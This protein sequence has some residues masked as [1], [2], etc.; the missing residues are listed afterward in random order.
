MAHVG[1]SHA[2]A[3]LDLPFHHIIHTL[4]HMQSLSSAI[5][6]LSLS[7]SL[8][9][10]SAIL[11]HDSI[12]VHVKS[13]A[14]SGLQR[15]FGRK[16][17]FRSPSPDRCSH[18]SGL[19]LNQVLQLTLGFLSCS[20]NRRTIKVEIKQLIWSPTF[21]GGFSTWK[22]SLPFTT[23]SKLCI[24]CSPFLSYFM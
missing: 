8:S 13:L 4:T 3:Y 11:H 24:N 14:R 18:G 10:Y 23:R 12:A 7:L 9:L 6:P 2:A 1:A 16:Q 19:D 15:F 5:F 17:F 21:P 20:E 22:L